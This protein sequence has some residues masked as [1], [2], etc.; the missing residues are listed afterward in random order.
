MTET[1]LTIDQALQQAVDHHRAGRLPEAERLYRAILQAHP[2][3]PDANHNL[4]VLAVGV[5]KPEAALPLFKT[6]LEAN[7]QVAQYWASYADGLLRTQQADSAR[8]IVQQ[9]RQHGHAGPALQQIEVRLAQADQ[10]KLRPARRSVLAKKTSADWLR[11]SKRAA[12]AGKTAEALRFAELAVRRDE[13]ALD[14]WLQVFSLRYQRQDMAGSIAALR[15]CVRLEPHNGQHLK[16]LGGVLVIVGQLG[17]ALEVLKQAIEINPQSPAAWINYGVCLKNLGQK[18]EASVA[19]EKA[20]VLDQNFVDALCNVASMRIDA[21][22]LDGALAVIDHA[23]TISPANSNAIEAKAVILS[24]LDRCEEAAALYAQALQLEDKAENHFRQHLMLPW[25]P[26]S[27][28]DITIWR[29][30]FQQG[31][32]TLLQNDS[33]KL[34]STRT[35]FDGL[36]RLPYHGQDDR[37]IMESLCRLYRAKLNQINY[38]A[39]FIARWQFPGQR[40]LRLGFCSDSFCSHPVGKLV[41]GF[42]KHL[43][44]SRLEAILIHTPHTEHDELRGKIDGFADR[45][46]NLQGGFEQNLREIAALE[47]DALFLPNATEKMNIYYAFARLAPVQF[48]SW[49]IANTSGIDTLDYYLS[50]ALIETAEATMHY[51]EHLVLLNVLPALFSFIVAP[52]TLPP[53]SQYGFAADRPIYF[54]PQSLFKYH[55]DFD[56]VLNEI[57][58]RDSAGQIVAI[59]GFSKNWTQRLRDRWQQRAPLLNERVTFLPRLEHNAYMGLVAQADVLLDTVHFGSGTSFYEAMYYG[60]PVVTWPG[61]FMRGRIVAGGYQQMGLA[62]TAPIANK[63]DEY[64]SLAVQWAND[65]TRR[66]AFR[67]R[68]LAAREKLLYNQQAV[69]ELEDFVLAALEAAARGE[70]LPTGWRAAERIA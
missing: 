11:Q 58:Q 50:S 24:N 46:V 51:S 8:Q 70:K 53:R 42:I 41:S 67:L 18:K 68:A 15:H 22:D 44:R 7:P 63:I 52:D 23:L 45:V 34:N 27:N 19:F 39:P 62:E 12:Q 64:A 49:G 9:A 10:G 65:P 28:D 6:A 26:Q 14:A 40:K 54:C 56:A 47:L 16:D 60:T 55:P 69:R 48:T 5:G 20:L 13:N 4:G 38:T 61:R 31:I 21:P 59:D 25:L 3:H 1:T 37:D 2:K 33:L 36:T 17:E 35:I 30:R 29:Q 57:A 32:V 43:D 66:Q